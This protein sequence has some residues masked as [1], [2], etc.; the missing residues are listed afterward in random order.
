MSK[1]KKFTRSEIRYLSSLPA[2]ARVTPSRITYADGFRGTA[3]QRYANGESPT[4][5]FREAGLDPSIIGYKRIERAFARWKE[6]PA[7]T[8]GEAECGEYRAPE[9]AVPL[10]GDDSND[11]LRDKVI[12]EQ[13][14]R[15]AKLE[16]RL[17]A[18]ENALKK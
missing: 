7:E 13:A 8:G 11:D 1:T 9:D 2:V 14:L 17:K 6:R 4:R 16:E 12:A 15:I 18:M 3:T 5:I 10:E